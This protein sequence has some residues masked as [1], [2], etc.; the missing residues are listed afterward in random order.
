M[1]AQ[2]ASL[3]AKRADTLATPGQFSSLEMRRD[4]LNSAV[5][6]RV[7]ATAQFSDGS[8]PSVVPHRVG[9]VGVA[10]RALL[11]AGVTDNEVHWRALSDLRAS[12]YHRSQEVVWALLQQ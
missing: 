2:A 3:R 4:A 9:G 5:L 7:V 8:L 6:H 10:V 11:V 12:M 1:H